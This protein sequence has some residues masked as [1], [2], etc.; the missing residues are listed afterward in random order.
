MRHLMKACLAGVLCAVV[1]S[2]CVEIQGH[3]IT[4]RHDEQADRVQVLLQYD[5]VHDSKEAPAGSPE[6]A[7]SRKKLR[8]FIDSGS[9]MFVDWWAHMDM[10][11]VKKQYPDVKTDALRKQWAALVVEHVKVENVGY[12]RD[13]R[14]HIGGAQLITVRNSRAWFGKLNAAINASLGA[15]QNILPLQPRTAQLWKQ[16]AS[17]G[18]QWFSMD[19]HAIRA[20][21]PVDRREWAQLKAEALAG[22]AQSMLEQTDKADAEVLRHAIA[23]LS[24]TPM[25]YVEAEGM[26]TIT[27]GDPAVVNTFRLRVRPDQ[28]YKANFEAEVQ[29]YGGPSITDS[30]AAALLKEERSPT[31]G[32]AAFAAWGPPEERVRALVHAAEGDDRNRVQL[33]LAKLGEFAQR[34]NREEGEPAAP[35]GAQVTDLDAWR[36][37]LSAVEDFPAG[38]LGPLGKD[39]REAA[40]ERSGSEEDLK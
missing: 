6:L 3:R 13:S 15:E 2:G 21:A 23:A 8:Q 22:L 28:E 34:W 27:L 1:P 33:A 38:D 24:S 19:G 11:A 25:S 14:G 4:I 36:Q 7:D 17:K 20:H 5:G 37:W 18:H 32:I 30:L 29:R 26:V 35:V 9:V 12:S 31:P 39:A 10:E 16:A 40:D